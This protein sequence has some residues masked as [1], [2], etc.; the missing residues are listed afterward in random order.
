MALA[1]LLVQANPKPAVLHIDVLDLHR[2]RRARVA[3]L[4]DIRAVAKHMDDFI[5]D[6]LTRRGSGR[7]AQVG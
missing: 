7:A 1:A 6:V 2:Q 4:Y 3:S 5:D